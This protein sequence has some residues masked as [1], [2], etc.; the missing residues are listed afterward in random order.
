MIKHAIRS[1]LVVGFAS[2]LVALV[3]STP[4]AGATGGHSDVVRTDQTADI[5]A[6]V[7]GLIAANP[8]ARETRS[9]TV[10]L[11][12]GVVVAVSPAGGPCPYLSLCIYDQP[13]TNGIQWN[14][15]NCGFVNIG[16]S[17]WSDRIRSFINNQTTGAKTIFWDWTGPETG[18]AQLDQSVALDIGNTVN[19]VGLTDGITVCYR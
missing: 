1:V 14:L 5:R 13:N 3:A 7:A 11:A 2:V 6:S 9:G 8:G 4:A 12:N 17:G 10:Q 19:R 15:F 16:L 18:W